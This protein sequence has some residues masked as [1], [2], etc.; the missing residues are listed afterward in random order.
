LTGNYVLYVLS[1]LHTTPA[2]AQVVIQ[3]GPMFFLLGGV[4]VLK[5][6]FSF[7]QW[8]GFAAL[9]AGLLLFFNMRLP[10]LIVV[11]RGTGLGVA[12]LVTA[13]IVWA[14]YGVAQKHLTKTFRPQQILLLIYMGAIIVL[15]PLA[16]PASIRGLSALQFWM[17]V[18]SCV[19]TLVAYGA[20]AE[21]L[22]HWEVSRVGA[23][24]A[25]APLVT[26]LS[27]RLV[28]RLFP[29]LLAPE[30]LSTLSVLGALLVVG[31]SAISALS[32][33]NAPVQP[34]HEPVFI[35]D[36]ERSS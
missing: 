21:A 28:N 5:E 17:L 27:T 31:G 2:V 23:V 13:A 20:F 24:L 19:N 8:I 32:A 26:L 7:G 4:V 36:S 15:F 14:A 34:P 6:N 9:V 25:L 11:S 10:E 18:F 22:D 3:L 30:G 33:S 29:G 35:S 1:L 16:S 12:L